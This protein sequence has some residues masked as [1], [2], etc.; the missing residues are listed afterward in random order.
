M[1]AFIHARVIDG[2]GTA[3]R[4]DT[5][6][7][8]DEGKIKRM[9]SDIPVPSGSITIDAT[10]KTIIPGLIDAHT[11]LSGSSLFTRPALCNANDSYDFA[12]G[13]E[14]CLRWGVTTVRTCGD[15]AD[16]MLGFV[17][18]QREGVALPGPRVI[19]CGPL[20][21]AKGGH[22]YYTVWEGNQEIFDKAVIC[23]DDDS[24]VEAE[25]D[26]VIDKGVDF[27]KTFF[28]HVD[29]TKGG[30]SVPRLSRDVNER[31]VKQA[32]RRGKKVC[33]HV[34]CVDEMVAA[35]EMGMDS[36]EHCVNVGS[37]NNQ[38]T[39]D[40]VAAIKASK[41]I[42]DPTI[43]AL[44]PWEDFLRF[45]NSNR[46]YNIRLTKRMFDAGVP[47]AIG[48]D[49]GIPMVPF[50]ESVHEEMA[51]FVSAGLDPITVIG[52]ATRGNAELLGVSDIT[53]SLEEGKQADLVML[54]ANPLA[55]IANTKRIEIVV[56]NGA[57]VGNGIQP[58]YVKLF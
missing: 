12:E 42:L 25:V 58:E 11:H 43:V 8:I 47:L 22:P 53:G 24:D 57:L 51:N 55:D 48:C 17:K 37:A 16:D 44:K 27:V 46:E 31:I 1:I 32:H 33:C 4:E 41:A 20:F 54:S 38:L 2:T 39:D 34:D 26:Q 36:I 45:Q 7:L 19:S 50:G 10:G 14:G 35:A 15:M 56:H 52:I 6:I 40:M 5:T 9:G 3:R 18:R 21:Q 29:R 13:R 49:S 23:L 28:G 30:K